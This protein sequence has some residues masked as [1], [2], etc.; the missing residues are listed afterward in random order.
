MP[1]LRKYSISVAVIAEFIGCV[2]AD[3]SPEFAFL[4]V[5]TAHLHGNVFLSGL[6]RGNAELFLAR[7]P[8]R[9]GVL[10]FTE[11]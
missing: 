10:P 7:Q 5:C 9:F 4:A 6:N 3:E 11:L 1:P 8:Q 2:D